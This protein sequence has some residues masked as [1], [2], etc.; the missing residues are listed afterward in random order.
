MANI[1]DAPT[2][3]VIQMKSALI[4]S[5]EPHKK[6]NTESEVAVMFV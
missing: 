4:V 2:V 3:I 6:N 5:L 1:S